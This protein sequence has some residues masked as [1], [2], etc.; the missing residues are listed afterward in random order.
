MSTKEKT[1]A[2]VL[3]FERLAAHFSLSD[4]YY[5]NYAVIP[6]INEAQTIILRRDALSE[7]RL[8]LE[9][10]KDG[11]CMKCDDLKKDFFD[12]EI[13][14]VSDSQSS[15]IAGVRC[16]KTIEKN[17]ALNLYKALQTLANEISSN[18][19]ARVYLAQQK[20]QN[21]PEDLRNFAIVTETFDL[22]SALLSKDV[23]ER[24]SSKIIADKDASMPIWL[25]M[26]IGFFSIV[27]FCIALAVAFEVVRRSRKKSKE[28]T[29]KKLQSKTLVGN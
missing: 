17:S 29:A 3:L 10:R 22:N 16:K 25:I 24:L 1:E 21:A 7:N 5:H 4:F 26:L 2:A 23:E 27:V 11:A 14:C 8:M 28:T 9:V 13:A 12:Q 6:S 19:S 18:P 15:I 20:M